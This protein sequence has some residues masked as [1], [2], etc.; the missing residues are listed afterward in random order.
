MTD[1]IAKTL[2]FVLVLI[3]APALAQTHQLSLQGRI[4]EGP[5]A[6]QGSFDFE[7]RYY[8]AAVGGAQIGATQVFANESVDGGRFILSVEPPSLQ[9]AWIDMSIRRA[10]A[11]TYSR[12]SP[13]GEL[14]PAARA[15]SARVA[16]VAENVAP[17]AIVSASVIPGSLTAPDSDAT[18]LQRRVASPCAAATAVQSVTAAGAVNCRGSIRGPQG[19]PGPTT[20]PNPVHLCSEGET[21]N[22]CTCTRKLVDIQITALNASC[23]VKTADGSCSADRYF[24]SAPGGRCCVC[25]P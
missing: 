9:P 11:S 17:G 19:D 7:L 4:S 13:R 14:K 16:G 10:G 6:T 8:S 23:W 21:P 20:R 1:A 12:L 18:E 25:A 3:A 15:R 22:D 5:A 24:T 2:A